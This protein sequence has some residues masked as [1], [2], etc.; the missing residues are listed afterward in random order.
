MGVYPSFKHNL[1][2]RSN[3]SIPGMVACIMSRPPETCRVGLIGG[4]G[5]CCCLEPPP[6]AVDCLE[7]SHLGTN[8]PAAIGMDSDD[9]PKV[10]VILAKPT[11]VEGV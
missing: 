11:E 8:S 9:C 1:S 7:I 6:V 3:G 5:G 2:H 4:G 10:F